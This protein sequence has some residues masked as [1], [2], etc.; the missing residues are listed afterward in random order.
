[1]A[2]VP[3]ASRVAVGSKAMVATGAVCTARQVRSHRG[4][5]QCQRRSS[6]ARLPVTST[7]G[8]RDRGSSSS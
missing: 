4:S 6:S 8:H 3:V 1:M 7:W 2:Q 5:L